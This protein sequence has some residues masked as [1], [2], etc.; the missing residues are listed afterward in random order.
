MSYPP[1]EGFPPPATPHPATP[2][3]ATAPTGQYPVQPPLPAQ[4]SGTPYGTPPPRGRST[5]LV[6]AIAAAVLLVFGGLM[7]GLY[8]NERGT[9]NDTKANLRDTRA[10]LTAQVAEQKSIVT[11][12]QEKLTQTEKRATDL[13][14]QLDKT[15]TSL[16]DVTAERDVLVPCMRRTEE[17]FSAATNGDE[18]GTIRALRA[19]RA[20]CD[21]AVIK[22]DS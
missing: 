22:I 9:L 15:K 14:T 5:V 16:A 10:D 4:I 19:A 21:R 7:F 20:A 1:Q 8:L 12:Q 3:P 11:E 6:L 2:H 18:S 17:I 13:S